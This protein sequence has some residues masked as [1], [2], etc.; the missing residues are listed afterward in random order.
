MGRPTIG[1]YMSTNGNP[2]LRRALHSIA[3]QPLLS[4]DRVLV[5]ADGPVVGARGLVEGY[6]FEYDE[7]PKRPSSEWG[8]GQVNYAIDKLHGSVDM[9]VG[10]D[11]DDIFAPRAF[12][13]LRSTYKEDHLVMSRVYNHAFG[14]LWR[15]PNWDEP[16]LKG[17]SPH[18]AENMA[19]DGHCPAMPG[20]AE[21]LAKFGLPYNG[22]QEFVQANRLLFWNRTVWSE[23]ITTITRPE[24]TLR[25]R[26]WPWFVQGSVLLE[27]LRQVRNECRDYMTGHTAEIT[28]E[29]QQNW[30]DHVVDHTNNWFYV[31]SLEPDA[32]RP[33]DFIAFA[34]LSYHDGTMWPT[35]G[36]RASHR[37]CGIGREVIQFTLIAAQGPLRGNLLASNEAVKKLDYE[38][39][40]NPIGE[41]DGI[42][43]V[44]YKWPPKFFLK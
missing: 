33:Q 27:A 40:W 22:D 38:L 24:T 15:V 19:L 28:P 7:R 42:I 34:A 29:Q 5:I 21:R 12:D 30:W 23:A 41:H 20:K 32:S 2:F 39:G 6:G 13:A 25:W 9:V 31:F 43:D 44:E 4:G 36:L 14:L 1:V 37:G 11:H 26:L 17:Q 35:Y 16:L 18:D 3:Q 10:Q 8:H